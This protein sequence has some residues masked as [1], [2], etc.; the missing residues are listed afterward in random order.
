MMKFVIVAAFIALD[1]LTGLVKAFKEKNYSSSIMREGLY[2]K[3]GSG[4]CIGVAALIDYGQTLFE[5][6]VT[7][8]VTTSICT[9][10]VLMEIGS[11]IENVC[12]IN[13]NIAPDKLKEHFQKL[14]VK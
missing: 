13:P 12:I 10:I 6:G 11:I 4:I 14:R 8:P 3:T 1:F 2:H 9:Y 7:V 5:L